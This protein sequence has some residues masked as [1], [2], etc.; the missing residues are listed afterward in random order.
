MSAKAYVLLN[1]VHEKQQ[2]VVRALRGKPG[3]LMVDVVEGPPDVVVVLGARGRQ[4]LAKLTIEAL[5]SVETMTEG[6]QLLPTRNRLSARGVSKTSRTRRN[7]TGESNLTAEMKRENKIKQSQCYNME[8]G[9][10]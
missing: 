4:R 9:D 6:L 2:Q 7:Q 5:A 10:A 3:V 1:V 8:A